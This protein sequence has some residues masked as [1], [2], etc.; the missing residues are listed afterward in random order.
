V[1]KGLLKKDID[2]N[3][4]KCYN[5]IMNEALGLYKDDEFSLEE[6]VATAKAILEGVAYRSTD[7]RVAMIPDARTVRYYQTVGVLAKP[8]RYE[9]RSAVYGY[10]HLL[11]LIAVKLLQA[12]GLSLAQIQNV[13][14]QLSL[15]DLEKQLNIITNEQDKI[16]PPSSTK[17]EEDQGKATFFMRKLEDKLSG[18]YEEPI[19][20]WVP[21][22]KKPTDPIGRELIAVE[23]RPGI[24]VMIDPARVKDASGVM[25]RIRR[26]LQKNL[27]DLE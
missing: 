22:Y 12:Q 3:Y 19:R 13:M 14:I 5:I 6:L 21:I 4:C 15:K 24:S 26:I 23:I 16:L 1:K 10:H 18:V 11:Q 27:G 8:L 17:E 2:S 20:D 25:E 9:G 7:G